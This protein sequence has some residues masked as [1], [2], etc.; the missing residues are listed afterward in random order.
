MGDGHDGIW[1]IIAEIGDK[2]QRIE[3]LDWYHLIE[4]LYKVEG[5]RYQ[6]EQ[7]KAYLWMGQISE[8]ISYLHSQK[9]VGGNQFCN[10][11]I[12]RKSRLI[13]YHY[14]S[15]LQICSIGSGAVESAVKQIGY[16]VKITGAQWKYENV[17]N[18]LQLRC[19]YLNGQLAI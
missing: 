8:A 3:I 19:A 2:N 6:L 18:I 15:W 16:R 9:L 17:N 1:N 5:K 4:N 13:N 12:K 7:V 10:Y 11:L 14:Y